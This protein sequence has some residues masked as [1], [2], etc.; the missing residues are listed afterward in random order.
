MIVRVVSG[1]PGLDELTSSEDE[2]GLG[3]GGIP[4]NTITLVYGPP[5]V[6]KSIFCHQFA[7][8]GLKQDEPCLYLTTDEN[9]QELQEDK[10]NFGDDLKKYMES[11]L[12]Y[13]VD[14]AS[15]IE[16][17]LESSDIYHISSVKNP[18]DILIK[19]SQGANSI[20]QKNPR[21]RAVIDSI[22]SILESNNE[23]LIVRVLKTYI[24]R[25]K[26][27]GGTA[28]INYTERSADLRTEILIKSMVDN[29]V[30]LN[31]NEIVIEAM[32]GMGIKNKSYEITEKGIIVE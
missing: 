24:L 30:K 26:E 16:E 31:G 1:I 8:Y 14:A 18:T 4:E 5:G 13:V 12:F 32:R 22:T 25:I 2:L 17:E 15:D 11:E 20:K 23:M 29:I 19:V 6:G 3:L 10:T 7:Y 21:F 27:A 28:V 9:L